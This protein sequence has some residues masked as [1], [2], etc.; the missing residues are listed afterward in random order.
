MSFKLKI[1]TKNSLKGLKIFCTKCK[2]KNP[3]CNHYDKHRFRMHVYVPNN[4]KKELTKVL[5]ALDYKTAFDEGYAFKKEMEACNFERPNTNQLFKK[6]TLPSAILKY[7]QYLSGSHEL[8]HLQKNVSSA[9]RDECIRYCRYF[10]N[11]VKQ[12]VD[13]EKFDV[14][15]T[16]DI[17]VANFY[18]WAN[19]KYSGKTFNKMLNELKAF[20]RFLIK[21]EKIKMEN[22]FETYQPK[23]VELSEIKSL[24]KS[25]FNRIIDAIETGSKFKIDSK[26]GKKTMYWPQLKEI[27]KLFLLTGGRREEVL[28]LRWCQLKSYEDGLCFFNIDNLK[29]NR[30]NKTKVVKSK[31]KKRLIAVN[32]D[33]MDLL[34]ELGYEHKKNTTDFIIYPER[35]CTIK[36]LMDRIS[37]SFTHYKEQANVNSEVSLKNLRKT[38]ITWLRVVMDKQTGLLSS[39]SSEEVL[40]RHYIDPTVLSAVEKAVLKLKVF[41]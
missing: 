4:P 26:G 17:D 6:Y 8:A 39:H 3:K 10:L 13:I 32:N 18:T 33:L 1:P 28:S 21:V 24:S 16:T 22:P 7:Y 29:V 14:I 36:T 5:G 41:G 19:D 23:Q 15:E 37:K 25:E 31:S 9:Y 35:T 20:F 40:E 38:Y 12:R 34:I 27:F 30:A 11:V 2:L